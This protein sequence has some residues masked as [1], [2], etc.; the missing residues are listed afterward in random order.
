[1]RNGTCDVPFVEFRVGCP[2][3]ETEL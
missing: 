2:A 1:M 3:L